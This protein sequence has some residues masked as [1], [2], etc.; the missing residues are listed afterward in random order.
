MA[1]KVSV[2]LVDDLDGTEAVET[3]T[4]GID[5]VNYEIDLSEGNASRLRDALSPYVGGGRKV[6]GGG[7]RRAPA[8]RGGRASGSSSSTVDT[9]SVREWARANGYQVADRGRI[10][11]EVI[12][13]YQAANG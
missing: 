5:G 6:G 2:Q 12:A 8:A 7:R 4:F 9:N 11:S 13:A 1:Q 3:L 10:K